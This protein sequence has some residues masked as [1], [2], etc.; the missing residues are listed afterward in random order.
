MGLMRT[1]ISHKPAAYTRFPMG[2][3]LFW[4]L[5]AKGLGGFGCTVLDFGF[6]L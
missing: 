2:V 6:A 4:V 1:F 3:A 5:R